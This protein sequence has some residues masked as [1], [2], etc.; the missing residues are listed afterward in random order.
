MPT[1]SPDLLYLDTS[2]LVKLVVDEPESAGLATWLDDRP[3]EVL[4]TSAIG[5]VELIRAA[6]RRGPEAIPLALHL[7][8]EVALVPVDHVVL[9]LAALLEPAGLRTLDA[10]HLASAGSLGEAVTA[11]VA[12]DE[13][14]L[15]AAGLVGLATASP[16]MAQA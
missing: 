7:F 3:D 15:A 16:G 4:C 10:L 13:R 12:Y 11:V 9:D 5:R 14:L 8:T 2:A 6:R 1:V